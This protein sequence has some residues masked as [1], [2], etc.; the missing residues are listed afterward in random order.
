M[1]ELNKGFTYEQV[2]GYLLKVGWNKELVDSA[3]RDII[4][5]KQI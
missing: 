4:S 1:K 2:K 3:I 5:R